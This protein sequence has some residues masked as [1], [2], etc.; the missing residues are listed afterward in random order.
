M[1]S[2][3]FILIILIVPTLIY[4][5]SPPALVIQALNQKFP[6]LKNVNWGK[7]N[8]TEWEA[9]FVKDGVKISALFNADGQWLETE[10]KI[11]TIYLPA[12]VN[13]VIQTN[14]KGLTL[15]GVDRIETNKNEVFYEA[16][17]KSGIR[18]KEVVFKPDGSL[19]K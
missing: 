3:F 12:E 1:K 11:P 8:K 16:E 18:I 14:Y 7:E 6:N 19:S 2:F 15:V 13:S 10:T 17:L 9:E 5:G 4:A